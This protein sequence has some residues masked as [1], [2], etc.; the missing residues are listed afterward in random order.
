MS[1]ALAHQLKAY[2]VVN[3]AQRFWY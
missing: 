1:Q 3:A 2:K